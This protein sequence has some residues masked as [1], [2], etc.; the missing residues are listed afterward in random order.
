MYSPQ[1]QATFPS[2]IPWKRQQA[3]LPV[4]NPSAKKGSNIWFGVFVLFCLAAV[5]F[6]VFFIYVPFNFLMVPANQNKSSV[7]SVER[8][9][10][11]SGGF[12]VVFP[13]DREGNMVETP[14]GVS[15]YMEEGKYGKLNVNIFSAARREAEIYDTLFVAIVEDN[16]DGEYEAQID[17]TAKDIFQN[18]AVK[19]VKLKYANTY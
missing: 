9:F 16:G 11:G 18:E 8:A 12:L 14:V 17:T 5:L 13:G 15:D 6:V 2:Q 19:K 4:Q 10:L 7:V 3:A 1:K